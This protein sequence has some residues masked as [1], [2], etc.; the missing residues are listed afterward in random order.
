MK[1]ISDMSQWYSVR[2]TINQSIGFVGT[3]GNLHTGHLSLIE[4]SKQD[5]DITVVSIFVNPTQFNNSQDFDNYPQTLE[6]DTTLL[7]Q[8]GVDY[9]LTPNYEQLYPHNYRFK[10]CESQLS[11]L[12]E[13]KYRPGHFDGMLTVV[14][15]LLQLVT[16]SNA[17][18]GEKDYQQYL[19]IKQMAESFLMPT[20]IIACPTIRESS[21]LAYSSRNSRLNEQ[22]KKQAEHFATLFHQGQDCE[23]IIIELKKA[24]INIDYIEEYQNRR[25]AAVHIDNIR[26]IDNYEVRP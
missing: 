2:R 11:Q 17:Y 18:F 9:C 21:S 24:D 25:Y 10:I 20:N 6:H 8:A 4:Q 14:M 23:S 15:K 13:G 19:L 5:N 16:P 1:I 3:M 22:Q 12:M 7:N 26:L